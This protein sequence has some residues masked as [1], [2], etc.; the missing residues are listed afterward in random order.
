VTLSLRHLNP[1]TEA[2]RFE[3]GRRLRHANPHVLERLGSTTRQALGN[4]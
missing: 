2:F 1:D 3:L 4:P